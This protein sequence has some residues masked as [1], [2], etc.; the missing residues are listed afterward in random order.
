[1]SLSK[2]GQS[3]QPWI[4]ALLRTSLSDCCLEKAILACTFQMTLGILGVKSCCSILYLCYV[5]TAIPWIMDYMRSLSASWDYF[6]VFP[7]SVVSISMHEVTEPRSRDQQVLGLEFEPWLSGF[8]THAP[9][10]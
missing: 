10:H 4:L 5:D 7:Q 8:G 1:M 2:P 6:K 3:H 9:K